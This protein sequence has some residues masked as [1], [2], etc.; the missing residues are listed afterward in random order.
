MQQLDQSQKSLYLLLC[1]Q[2]WLNVALD[3]LVA[4]IAVGV[5]AFAVIFQT[6]TTGAQVGVA[7][8]M[9]LVVSTTLLRLVETWTTLEISLG[10]ISRLR[11]MIENVPQEDRQSSNLLNPPE[12]W[13]VE[14]D[15]KIENMT[16]SYELV[17]LSESYIQFS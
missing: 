17:P 10:S 11:T 9:I 3:L 6:T 15:V 4:G 1:L 2:R 5:V 14:G 13:P 7:L 8:N 12:N 16:V